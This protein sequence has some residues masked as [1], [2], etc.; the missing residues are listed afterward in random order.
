MKDYVIEICVTSIIIVAFL[1]ITGIV[2]CSQDYYNNRAQKITKA[3][4][5]TNG[6]AVGVR[7]AFGD[8]NCQDNEILA[9]MLA[10]NKE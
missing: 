4:E 5:I 2:R 1:C 7:I 6:D 9:Y 8:E 10:K 3:L